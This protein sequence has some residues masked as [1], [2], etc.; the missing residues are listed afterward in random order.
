MSSN[1]RSR[2]HKESKHFKVFIHVVYVYL[3][4][5]HALSNFDSDIDLIIYRIFF[6]NYFYGIEEECSAKETRK[7]KNLSTP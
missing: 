1:T 4:K 3:F 5:A 6:F 7:Q 2:K